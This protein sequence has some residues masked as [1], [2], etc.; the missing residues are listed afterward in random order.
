VTKFNSTQQLLEKYGGESPK[1][2]S[3]KSGGRSKKE[4]GGKARSPQASGRTGLPP[5]ATANIRRPLDT[6]V[7]PPPGAAEPSLSRPL[8]VGEPGFAPNAFSAPPPYAEHH[9]WYDRL[10][11]VL[12]GEDETLPKNRFAL[13]C[14]ACRLVNGRAPPGTKSLEELGRWRCG[15]CGAWNGAEN[16]AMRV[17][18]DIQ[19]QPHAGEKARESKDDEAVSFGGDGDAMDDSDDMAEAEEDTSLEGSKDTTTT[20]ALEP[21][22]PPAARRRRGRPRVNKPD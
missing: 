12:L 18:A 21:A 13:I 14:G 1:P 22:E 6:P 8:S 20:P 2:P 16:E 9:H 19:G 11:D 7:P 10:L 15:S 17:L 4:S 3:Q 5:P